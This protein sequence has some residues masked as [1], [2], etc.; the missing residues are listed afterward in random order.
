M[1]RLMSVSL[2]ATA[3][4]ARAKTVTRR[5]GWWNTATDTPRLRPGERLWLCRKVMGR[6]KGEPLDRLVEV[7]VVSCTREPLSEIY[8]RGPEEVA[9]EGFPGRSPEWFIRFFCDHMGV[10]RDAL[11]T[12]I[13][14]RYLDDTPAARP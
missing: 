14:W 7:E 1:A 13:E 11:V 2:T 9:A 5:V 3:V 12:R 10:T 6:A 8:R 4:E